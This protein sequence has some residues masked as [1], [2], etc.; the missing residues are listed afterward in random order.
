MYPLDHVRLYDRPTIPLD[1]EA[2]MVKAE[3]VEALLYGSVTWTLRQE[4]Y[5][6]LRTVHHRV[7]LH[8]IGKQGRS[9]DHRILSYC[10]ALQAANCESIETTVRTRRLLW[11]GAVVVVVLT[12]MPIGPVPNPTCDLL[13][14]ENNK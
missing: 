10:K 14:R 3:A 9:R 8:I 6:M 5:K 7:L 12:F 13:N 1:L 11:A 4:Y 2:R